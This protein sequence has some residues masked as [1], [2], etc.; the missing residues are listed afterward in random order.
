MHSVTEDKLAQKSNQQLW[1]EKCVS[2]KLLIRFP[3]DLFSLVIMNNAIS[4]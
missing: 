4:S 2:T 1:Q 3:R